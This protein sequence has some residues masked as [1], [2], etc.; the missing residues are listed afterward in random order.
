MWVL[1]VLTLAMVA[2][3]GLWF[4]SCNVYRALLY[5]GGLVSSAW[6]ATQVSA[7]WVQHIPAQAMAAVVWLLDRLN[8][9]EQAVV[10]AAWLP[11]EPAVFTGNPGQWVVLH[12]LRTM[13]YTLA[14]FAVFTAFS[15]AG[16]LRSVLWEQSS[17]PATQGERWLCFV[18]GSVCGLYLAGVACVCLANLAWVQTL[19]GLAPVLN[20]SLWIHILGGLHHWMAG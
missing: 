15:M 18:L 9:P 14:T 19:P 10:A 12:I 20:D 1:D 8:T 6:V 5:A 3:C 4:Q 2:W 7:W 16:W 11:P 17:T 13:A